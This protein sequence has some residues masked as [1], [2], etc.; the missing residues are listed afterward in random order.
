MAQVQYNTMINSTKVLSCPYIL[1]MQPVGTTTKLVA[2]RSHMISCYKKSDICTLP[3]Y[4]CPLQLGGHNQ[5]CANDISPLNLIGFIHE[6]VTQ[7]L[8]PFLGTSEKKKPNCSKS[9]YQLESAA[10]PPSL[11]QYTLTCMFIKSLFS[12]N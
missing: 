11:L 12:P 5:I 4:S 1:Q 9:I 2:P 10:P 6:I 3:V 8:Y 7:N